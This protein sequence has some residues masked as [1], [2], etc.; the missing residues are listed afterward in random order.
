MEDWL[1][2]LWVQFR[3]LTWNP[4]LVAGVA[5][6]LI[7]VAFGGIVHWRQ[8][9]RSRVLPM[10]P[11]HAE[12]L[13]G[14]PDEATRFFAAAHEVTMSVTE[15]WNAARARSSGARVETVIRREV[16]RRHRDALVRAESA[17]RSRLQGFAQLADRL[18]LDVLSAMWSYRSRDNYRTVTYTTTSTDS[19]GRTRTQIRT[20]RVY[21]S[22]DHWFDFDRSSGRRAQL[23]TRSWLETRG[24]TALTALGVRERRVDVARLAPAER[25]FLERLVRHT[26]FEDPE[27][28]VS[29][30]DLDRYANQWLLGTRIDADL[31]AFIDGGAA[32]GPASEAA[33]EA[34]PEQDASFHFCTGS[35]THPGPRGYPEFTR[36]RD[37][38]QA[39]LAAWSSVRSLLS[40]C[41]TNAHQLVAMADDPET[42]EWDREYAELAIA[43]YEEAFPESALEI[44]QLT[45]GRRTIAWSAL[46]AL[47]GGALVYAVHPAGPLSW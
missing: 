36:A 14:E 42:V 22:T 37:R 8:T 33:F 9:L 30:G 24:R 43:L 5:G 16:L 47:L 35:R 17:L 6:L 19:K 29:D 44:D 3:T 32:L 23:L 11:S 1:L 40:T 4:E 34:M 45:R 41:V 27:A 25:S 39:A 46:V 18:P 2:G 12:A 26:V 21:D 31:Q 20:R 15:A 28:V 7:G 38:M 13:R 10:L